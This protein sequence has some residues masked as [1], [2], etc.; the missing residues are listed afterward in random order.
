M[1]IFETLK[2]VP[3]FFSESELQYLKQLNEI[4]QSNYDTSSIAVRLISFLNIM[5]IEF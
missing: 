1:D 3:T 4:Y 5:F 2:S